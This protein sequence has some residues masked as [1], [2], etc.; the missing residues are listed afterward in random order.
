VSKL[1]K[2]AG[3]VEKESKIVGNSDSLAIARPTVLSRASEVAEVQLERDPETGEIIG[4]FGDG[5]MTKSNPLNDPLNDVLDESEPEEWDAF[6]NIP[7]HPGTEQRP[8]IEELEQLAASGIR[9]T[10]RKQSEREAEWIATLVKKY[11]DDYGKM[12]RDGKLNPMQQTA[13]DIKRRVL[14]WQKKQQAEVTI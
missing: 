13:G 8:V 9:K 6:G 4:V 14:K 12:V 11:G 2:R 5:P 10:P 1:N 7:A 3:G